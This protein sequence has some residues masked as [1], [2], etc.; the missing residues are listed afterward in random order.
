MSN[1][2]LR[3]HGTCRST[4]VPRTGRVAAGGAAA[5]PRVPRQHLHDELRPDPSVA[6]DA[7]VT[8]SSSGRA[9]GRTARRTASSA[10]ATPR[11]GTP[12]GPEFR[13][14]TYTTA[15]QTVLRPSPPTP[16]ATS[17]SPGRADARTGRPGRLRASATTAPARR[18]AA[19]S[20]STPY[21]TASQYAPA[22]AVA[23]GNFVVAWHSTGQDGR[24][25][26][27]YGQRYAI[28]GTAPGPEF[29]VNTYTTSCSGTQRRSP[30][31]PPA[32]S[33]SSG[34]ATRRT[35]TSAASSAS[36]I[37]RSGI[38]LGPEFRVNTYTT[39]IQAYPSVAADRRRLRRRLGERRTG[40]LGHRRLRPALTPARS[41]R[42]APSSASTR[43]RQAINTAVR[44]RRRLAG[45]F[46]VVWH[47]VL[48][49]GSGFGVF[50]QRYDRT[51]TGVPSGP[52]FR[53]N[54]YT[55]ES[56]YV[57][58]VAAG[59]SGNFVVVWTSNAQ[60]GS[61]AGIF[62]RR[63]SQIVPVELMHFRVE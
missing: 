38:P 26:G 19:S 39:G 30:P 33:W 37:A 25:S 57:A 31:T 4:L 15:H 9:T 41:S 52:E 24:S 7:P 56:Q 28:S 20:A 29:R 27:V 44:R 46:V 1:R 42:S 32:T 51:S 35:A 8:S 63:Y 43:I 36:A 6:A 13:V 18:W 21:T 45:N 48:Q 23:A 59:T 53:V 2:G 55:T 50:G 54:T 12:L 58:A 62:G 10:S 34:R 61:S 17:S 3:D 16:P 5:R 60:D 11:R 14:N 47:S 40:R 22:V 49:D